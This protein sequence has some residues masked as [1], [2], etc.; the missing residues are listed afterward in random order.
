M[1]LKGLRPLLSDGKPSSALRGA[2]LI[3]TKCPPRPHYRIALAKLIGDIGTGHVQD[4]VERHPGQERGGERGGRARATWPLS[5]ACVGRPSRSRPYQHQ[6]WRAPEL[7]NADGQS[8]HDKT[9]ERVQQKGCTHTHSMQSTSCTIILS[10]FTK[11]CDARPSWAPGSR[12]G[13]RNFAILRN[14]PHGVRK[15]IGKNSQS[16]ERRVVAVPWC[17]SHPRLRPREGYRLGRQA[18]AIPR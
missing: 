4:V 1:I 9:G 18:L 10:V 17:T 11:R 16:T 5:L 2:R 14:E 8:P 15:A 13:C 3:V 7:F 12:R 6:L